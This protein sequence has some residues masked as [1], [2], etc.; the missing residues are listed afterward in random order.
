VAGDLAA[1]RQRIQAAETLFSAGRHVRAERQLRQAVGSLTRR[2]EWL[3]AAQGYLALARSLILRGRP[4][5]ALTA[6]DEIRKLQVQDG[7]V[8][9]S[10][11]AAT[12][13]GRAALDL[14][15]LDEAESVLEAAASTASGFP[16]AREQPAILLELSRLLFWRGRYTSASKVL[17]AVDSPGHDCRLAVMLAAARSRAA[18]GDENLPEAVALATAA[19]AAAES[20][21]H[22]DLTAMSLASAAFAHLA[23]GD[24]RAVERECKAG[25]LAARQA[26]D[27]LMAF[28][29][30]LIAAESQ[31]RSGRHSMSERLVA[32]I[33]GGDRLLVPPI[34]MARVELLNDL[35]KDDRPDVAARR[36]SAT[37]LAALALFA[38]A[39]RSAPKVGRLAADLVEIVRCCQR[40]EDDASVLRCLAARLRV[41]LQASATAVLVEDRNQLVTLAYDGGRI[42]QTR[43]A[44]LLTIGD[45]VGPGNGSASADG[46]TVVRYGGQ[47]TG[48]LAVRWAAPPSGNS[49]D[50]L[51][52][53]STAAAVAGPA[54]AAERLR[55]SRPAKSC[56]ELIGTSAEMER[57]RQAIERASAAPF[58]VLVEGESGTGKELVARA[59]HNTSPRRERPRC[60]VNC[61]A[62]PDDLIESEL[63]GHARGAFTGAMVERPGVFEEANGGTLFLDEI[64][65]LSLRAQA[66]VLRAIQEGE[67]RRIGENVARRVDTRI[68]AASNRDL[69]QEVAA[70]RFRMDLLYRLDVIR[71]TLPPLHDR[72][73][74]IPLL[75]EYFWREAV[76]RVGSHATLG[77]ATMAALAR[78]HWPGNVRELQ[79]VLAALAVRCPRRGVVA[80]SALPPVFDAAR[81]SSTWRLEDARRTFEASFVRA[82]LARAGG[83]RTRAARE[84]GVTRQGLTKLIAR[85]GLAD[86]PTAA[87]VND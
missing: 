54:L 32:R 77:V 64:S 80:P 67:I 62:L 30:R 84:L 48:V 16:E 1:L 68:V 18:L 66:K 41:A 52:I 27:P 45:V 14:L 79:N 73:E 65:E 59:L 7:P 10:L 28:R 75:A 70:G 8:H 26:H 53:L 71:I 25:L 51:S 35:L 31:R 86:T 5:D 56:P 12:L 46:G 60:T 38:P 3:H 40:A 87:M 6:I 78:Y 4:R 85:L 37:G 63:F 50:Y 29:I 22:P 15:Q 81:P 9:V 55:R 2:R 17:R 74:D 58:A 20:A 44:Q 36:A 83:H 69:R 43:A 76:T 39:R 34:L 23:V 72:V 57:V 13:A 19:V 33:R 21:R 49:V 24:A 42:D 82:A 47:V 61:A 11:A